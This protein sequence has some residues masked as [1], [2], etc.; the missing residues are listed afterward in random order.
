MS[1]FVQTTVSPGLIDRL[2]GRKHPL[3]SSQPGIE[4]PGA[5]FTSTVLSLTANAFGIIK[6]PTEQTTKTKRRRYFIP[7][8]LD[9]STAL[10]TNF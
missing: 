7:L 9:G 3:V 1:G 2:S 5:F 10:R 4:E 8:S 6:I